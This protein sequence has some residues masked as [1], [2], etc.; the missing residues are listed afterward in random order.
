MCVCDAAVDMSV[1]NQMERNLV[2]T[3]TVTSALCVLS[4]EGALDED[5]SCN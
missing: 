3:G 2:E 5:S 4:E 1:A